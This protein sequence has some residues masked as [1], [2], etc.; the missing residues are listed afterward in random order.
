MCVCEKKELVERATVFCTHFSKENDL[1]WPTMLFWVSHFSIACT[2][3]DHQI[4]L[5]YI[6]IYNEAVITHRLSSQIQNL[7]N[8]YDYDVLEYLYHSFL[9]AF[10]ISKKVV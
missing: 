10:H 2:A 8:H 9:K 1:Q 6:Y 7:V 3:I 4:Y 5:Y